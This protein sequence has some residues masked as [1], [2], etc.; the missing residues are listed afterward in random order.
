[1]EEKTG[2][3]FSL[4]LRQIIATRYLLLGDSTHYANKPMMRSIHNDEKSQWTCPSGSQKGT[5]SVVSTCPS[6]S[7]KYWIVPFFVLY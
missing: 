4:M 3:C 7:I 5:S 6:G 2:S 1:M